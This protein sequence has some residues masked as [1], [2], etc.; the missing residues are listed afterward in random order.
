MLGRT[1]IIGFFGLFAFV[2]VALAAERDETRVCYSSAET[3]EAVAK[4][5][6]ADPFVTLRKAAVSAK[7]EPLASRLCKWGEEYVYE[8]T[9]LPK[10]GK[11]T[12]IFMRAADGSPI[13]GEKK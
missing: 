4:F 13:S 12:R 3:R 2:T 10:S 1:T 11:V 5:R 7:A 9:L 6:L 8:M